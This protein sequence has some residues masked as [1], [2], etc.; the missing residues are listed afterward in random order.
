MPII[1]KKE[2][3]VIQEKD[4]F[5]EYLKETK[6]CNF[7]NKLIKDAVVV[8]RAR[9]R[10]LKN[11]EP[12]QKEM[13]IRIYSFVRDEIRFGLDLF[14]RKASETLIRKIG[15]YSQKANLQVALLR[16]T[17]IPAR[18]H[19]V[20][21]P[22]S[23]FN[24]IFAKWQVKYLSAERIP[25]N[26]GVPYCEAY[27]N[28]KWIACQC[29]FDVELSPHLARSWD[30]ERNLIFFQDKIEEDLGTTNSIDEILEKSKES[31]VAK[32][33]SSV[34]YFFINRYLDAI[35]KR[36]REQILRMR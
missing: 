3:R 26:L 19:I 34:D 11:R 2:K 8:L 14:Y 17:K 1:K 25:K 30:G 9:E 36:Q 28:N 23:V 24:E 16:N 12:N 4:T 7:N 33:V 21:I 15:F 13:A 5:A 27:L 18:F 6:L 22:I 10:E 29:L 35:R 32:I 31:T 20:K